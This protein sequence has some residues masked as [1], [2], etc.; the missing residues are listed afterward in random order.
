MIHKFDSTE[1]REESIVYRGPS[2]PKVANYVTQKQ[3]WVQV[4]VARRHK[5][6]SIPAVLNHGHKTL[7]TFI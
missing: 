6:T 1:S 7:Q 3:L 4:G 2:I 5:K